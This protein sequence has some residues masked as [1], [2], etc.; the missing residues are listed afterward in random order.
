MNET[1][2]SMPK[3]YLFFILKVALLSASLATVFSAASVPLLISLEN[4]SFP[5][6]FDSVETIVLLCPITAVSSGLFA[7]LAGFLGGAVILLG[8]KHI[9]STKALLLEVAIIGFLLGCVSLF[10]RAAVDSPRPTDVQ[11]WLS[12]E[13]AFFCWVYGLLAIPLALTCA[14]LLR[15]SFFRVKAAEQ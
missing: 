6:L 13:L 5:S 4:H 3:A 2:P 8:R 9:R 12:R 14:F 15:R 7:L 11:S 1:Q 10:Y